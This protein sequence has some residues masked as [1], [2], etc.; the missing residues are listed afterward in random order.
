MNLQ[1]KVLVSHPSLTQGL[2]AKSVVYIYQH[3]HKGSLGVI[4]NKRSNY[5]VA[6]IMAQK[7]IMFDHGHMCFTGGPVNQQA[8]QI[9]HSDDWYSQNTLQLPQGLS[10]SSD[11]VML[12]KIA[13]GNQPSLWRTFAGVSAWGPDQLE[14]EIAQPNGWMI[15]QADYGL[16][17]DW[18]STEQWMKAIETVSQS[19]MDNY[20]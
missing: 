7:G 15:A 14:K 4:L 12:E 20:I 17:Y 5:S 16:I 3:E 18:S 19:V 11:T 6:E 2:F 9:L 1:G 13:M 8:L 10:I